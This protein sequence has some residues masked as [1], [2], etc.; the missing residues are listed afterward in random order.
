MS[1]SGTRAA[2]RSSSHR[3]IIAHVA[4]STA[5]VAIA[6]QHEHSARLEFASF[7]L[8]VGKYTRAIYTKWRRLREHLVMERLSF[9]RLSH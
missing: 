6:N 4:E 8:F 7:C 1:V 9:G 2:S 5:F 3:Q